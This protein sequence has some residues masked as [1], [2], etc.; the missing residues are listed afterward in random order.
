MKDKPC[1]LFVLVVWLFVSPNKL[2]GNPLYTL[3]CT[4]VGHILRS[5]QKN[6]QTKK[7]ID[8]QPK[9]SWYD[10]L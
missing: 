9:Y 7:L 5:L 1:R 10:I 3:H 8:D 4:Q 2:D 6:K